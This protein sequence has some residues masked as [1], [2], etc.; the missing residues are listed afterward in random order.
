MYLNNLVFA[1]FLVIILVISLT[2]AQTCL[3][4][5]NN[6]TTNSPF[7]RNRNL[8]LTSLPAN[9]SKDGGF[10][11]TSIGED[12]PNRVYAQALCRGDLS[13]E[14]CLVYVNFTAHQLLSSCKNQTEAFS[15]DGD[16]P[17]LVRYSDKS[18]FGVLAL[19]PIQEAINPNAITD[20]ASNLTLFFELW[21]ELMEAVAKKASMGSSKLKYATGVAEE[22]QALMQCTPDLFESNCLTCLRT[23]IRRY[24][25]CCRTYQ[26]GYVETPSCRMRWDLYTFFSPTADTVRLSLSSPPPDSIDNPLATIK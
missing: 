7:A 14:D 4:T 6:F 26:G 3:E 18:L 22:I 8:I 10:F 25:E 12:G 17:C 21:G 5:G 2:N 13:G 9:V 15:W 1:F 19:E 16:I 24:T 11:N 23:L 20:V